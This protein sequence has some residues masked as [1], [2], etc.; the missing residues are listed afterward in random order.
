MA[1]RPY[2]PTL[3]QVLVRDFNWRMGN[4][5]R[6]AMNC[7][8]LDSDLERKAEYC[9]QVQTSREIANHQRRLHHA[10]KGTE[11]IIPDWIWDRAVDEV[12]RSA[13]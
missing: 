12:K 6:L 7:K 1:K 3:K 8:S 2:K 9:V 5:R 13:Q 4:L 10:E 11:S